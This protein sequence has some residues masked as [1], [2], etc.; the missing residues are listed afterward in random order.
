MSLLSSHITLL[1]E[2]HLEAAVHVMAHVGKKYNYRL[3]YNLLYPDI[4]HSVFKECDLSEFYR[5]AKVAIQ[6]NTLEPH[7]NEVG[8]HMFV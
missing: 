4:D 8:I 3:V 2:G 5:D 7:G 1:R 6:V